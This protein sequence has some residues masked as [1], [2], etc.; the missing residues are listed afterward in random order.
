MT[1]INVFKNPTAMV[2]FFI[3]FG[4][5]FL[6]SG[7]FFL[8]K[9]LNNGFNTNFQDGD[10]NSVLFTCLGIIFI[11]KGVDDLFFRRYYIEWDDNELR[12]FL[13][14]TKNLETISLSDI[15]HI[16]IKLFKIELRLR[17]KT[18]LINLSNLRYKDL[19]KIK[20]KFEELEKSKE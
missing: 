2:R 6:I 14:D 18:R 17:D 3:I 8:I 15:G 10:W 19:R 7:I 5:L 12:L 4:G 16:N 11:I 13:P 20:E 9:A 1:R